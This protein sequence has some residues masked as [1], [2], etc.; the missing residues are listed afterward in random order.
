MSHQCHVPVGAAGV[1]LAILFAEVA[2]PKA[3]RIVIAAAI[4]I[5]GHVVPKA[6][7]LHHRESSELRT[8]A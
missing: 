6:H 8:S 3:R 1:A 2:G 7:A 5:A 4:W